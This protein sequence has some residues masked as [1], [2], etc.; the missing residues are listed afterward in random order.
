MKCMLLLTLKVQLSKQ[1][2]KPHQKMIQKI[3]IKDD[4]A[5][6]NQFRIKNKENI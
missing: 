6:I 2:K 1:Y 3:T 4:L 5:K